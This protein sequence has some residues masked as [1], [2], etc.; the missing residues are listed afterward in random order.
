MRQYVDSGSSDSLQLAREGRVGSVRQIARG[1][2]GCLRHGGSEDV[3]PAFMGSSI[4]TH[5]E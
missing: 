1:L 4:A 3:Q 5:G 2:G